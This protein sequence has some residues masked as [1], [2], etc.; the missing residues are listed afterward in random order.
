MKER[1][2]LL[3]VFSENESAN[4]SLVLKYKAAVIS[5]F[6]QT[7]HRNEGIVVQ[8]KSNFNNIKL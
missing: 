7:H 5:H 6:A 3:Q 8:F 1:L 2:N 4:E